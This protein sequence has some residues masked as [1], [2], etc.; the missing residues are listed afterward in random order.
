MAVIAEIEQAQQAKTTHIKVT[1]P[2]SGEVVNEV[3]KADAA[4]VM[5]AIERARRAQVEWAARSGRE[6]AKVFKRFHD[7][8]IEQRDE[9]YDVLQAE[10]GKSR[11]D[12][13]VEL[14]AICATTRYYSV[15]GRRFIKS[16]RI[17]PAIPFRDRSKVH[18][19]PVGVVGIISPWNFP[20]IL[21]LDDAIPALLAGN[22]VVLKPATLTPL[23]ALWGREKLIEAG[24]PKDLLQIVIGR[25][26]EL[27]NPLIDNVEY[28]MFTGST[29]TGRVV[30]E[31]AGHRLVPLSMELGGKNA[32]II[33][34][35]AQLEHAARVAIE[36]TY[37]NCGQACINFERIFVAEEIYDAFVAEMVRQIETLRLGDTR[38]F[39]VDI[40]SL[41]NDEQI[42][43]VQAH[44]ND[45]LEHGAEVLAGGKARPDLG[46]LFYEPTLL[47]NV[48]PGM[49]LYN[50]ETFGPVA[51]VYKF[52]DVE[53]AIERANDTQYG[54]HASVYARDR[55]RAEAVAKRLQAGTVAVNDSYMNWATVDG[56]MG[57]FKQSGIGRRHGPEG[58]RRF[59]EAQTITTNLWF[60][61]I[62]SYETSLSINERLADLLV[63]LLRVWRHIPFIR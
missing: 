44:V 43:T 29:Q 42:D 62:S 60:W 21:A 33:L 46:P 47:E 15:H 23:A 22:G 34:E 20:F 27:G 37:N 10:S 50:E 25:G 9:L 36:G 11:R 5:I 8:I 7:L 58:I 53:D 35:D 6:R 39:S 61:Q 48:R 52:S 54:L 56:P 57:G 63:V 31:R 30:A 19:S 16:R 28:V 32:M 17:K 59:T 14:F 24:L 55:R 18:Y 40:G 3:P 12:A 13:F 4:D 2:I 26:S 1:N 45:A 49:T 38:D 51:A 41:I